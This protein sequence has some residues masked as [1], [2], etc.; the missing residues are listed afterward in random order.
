M[1]SSI[2]FLALDDLLQPEMQAAVLP[3]IRQVAAHRTVMWVT[4]RS[5]AEVMAY[6]TAVGCAVP[7]IA[8]GGSVLYLPQGSEQFKLLP[9]DDADLSD[10]YWVVALAGAYVQARAGLRVL[11]NELHHS[12]LGYGDMTIDRLQKFTGLSS[13]AAQRAKARE[14][15]EPFITP[16]AVEKNVLTKAA[17]T[18]GFSVVYRERVSYLLAEGV[19]V[20]AAIA[21]ARSR[22][23]SGDDGQSQ[24]I[25]GIGRWPEDQSW[26]SAVDTAIAMV[27]VSEM[28]GADIPLT[29]LSRRFPLTAAG[30]Q[31]ALRTVLQP[32]ADGS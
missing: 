16:K 31:E 29:T 25:L 13:E 14:S 24:A 23:P 10:G 28:S 3:V 15:S 22:Y 21:Q 12:L 4:Q 18:L 2:A 11:A 7:F 5:G 26:L 32:E 27:P 17:A 9:D 8:E 6:N 19:S 20:S 30:W 1:T